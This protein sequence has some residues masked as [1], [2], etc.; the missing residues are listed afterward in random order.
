LIQSKVVLV[1]ISSMAGSAMT[2]FLA[3]LKLPMVF[4]SHNPRI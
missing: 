4:R 1:Q 3:I 2:S